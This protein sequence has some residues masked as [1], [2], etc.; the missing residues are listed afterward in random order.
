MEGVVATIHNGTSLFTVGDSLE[1]NFEGGQ[2]NFTY[3]ATGFNNIFIKFTADA[4]FA[5]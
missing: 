1:V 3:N 2:R 4:S 5:G